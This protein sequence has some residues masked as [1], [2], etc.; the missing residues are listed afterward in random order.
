M[1]RPRISQGAAKMSDDVGMRCDRSSGGRALSRRACALVTVTN[2]AACTV[3]LPPAATPAPIAPRIE[4][5]PPP[6]TGY[7]RLVVDVVD[8]ATPVYRVQMTPEELR[9]PKG[10]VRYR[11]VET[12]GPLC[13]QTPCAT[14]VPSGNLAL[15]FPVTGDAE[16]LEV[17]LVHVGTEVSVYRRALSTHEGR[18][19]G[20]TLS[21]VGT[22]IGGGA[23]MTGAA[24]LPIGL[25]TD[26]DGMTLAGAISLGAGA[27]LVTLGVIGI[28]SNAA[29]FRPGASN[30]FPLPDR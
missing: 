12:R 9:D 7:G 3:Q 23:L 1:K 5:A 20:F 11:F 19:G 28:R 27:L 10:R 16:R 17:E 24:L 15:G 4:A 13:E 26:N 29:R 2:I 30:H 14:D 21:V 18:G 8:G 6:P 25:G 22:S